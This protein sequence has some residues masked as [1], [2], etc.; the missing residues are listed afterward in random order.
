[1]KT[2]IKKTLGLNNKWIKLML[3]VS[4]LVIIGLTVYPDQTAKH[5]V[6]SISQMPETLYQIPKSLH[7]PLYSPMITD[8]SYY[9]DELSSE[10]FDKAIAEYD[11]ALEMPQ[12]NPASIELDEVP[13]IAQTE[14]FDWKGTIS[15]AIGAVNA[16]VLLALN[17]KNL[18]KKKV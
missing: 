10:E 15:W 7:A 5:M 12:R 4:I 9:E 3:T 14:P 8:S 17:I 13:V 6:K 2:K 18:R 1:M 11:N 16:I